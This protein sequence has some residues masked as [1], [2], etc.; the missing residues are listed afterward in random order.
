MPVQSWGGWLQML[1]LYGMNRSIHL[2][3]TIFT[4]SWIL[5]S[6]EILGRVSRRHRG[7]RL[8]MDDMSF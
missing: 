3:T 5:L 7:M 8:N 4:N 6:I 1:T 2:A